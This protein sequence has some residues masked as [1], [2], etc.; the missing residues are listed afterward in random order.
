MGAP[1]EEAGGSRADE[2]PRRGSVV[3]RVSGILDAFRSGPDRLL[4]EEVAA[5][6]GLPR[7]TTFRLMRQLADLGWLVH[8]GRGYGLGDRA[9][10]LSARANDYGGLRTAAAGTVNQLYCQLGAVVHL[11]VLEG[12]MLVYLDK[13]GGPML[14]S[15]P[16][17]V[18]G[19]LPADATPMGRAMLAALAPER[20]DALVLSTVDEPRRHPID[21]H[22]LHNQLAQ[23][24]QR[25]YDLVRNAG[26]RRIVALGAAAHGPDGLLAS[27][28]ISSSEGRLTVERA[29]PILLAAVRRLTADIGG[30][31]SPRRPRPVA[32][33]SA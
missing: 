4:L 33:E 7:S 15:I 11:A 17:T 19:R 8:D 6:A 3:E 9:V 28:G 1:Q 29:A 31:N 30:T 22:G 13:L 23:C 10:G 2:K 5:L 32:Q 12:G 24:R 18:G 21:L 27:I 20:V 16:S 26:P 25:G 14:D